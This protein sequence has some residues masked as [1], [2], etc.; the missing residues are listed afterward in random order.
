MPKGETN[1]QGF[2]VLSLC[3]VGFLFFVVVYQTCWRILVVFQCYYIRCY[4]LFHSRACCF[5]AT[6]PC[7]GIAT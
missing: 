7:L 6:W 4:M 3:F 1:E 2:Y 5:V